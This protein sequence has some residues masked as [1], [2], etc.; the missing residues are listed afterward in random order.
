MH[1]QWLHS[2]AAPSNCHQH[3]AQWAAERDCVHHQGG[4]KVC[5]GEF[6]AIIEYECCVYTFVMFTCTSSTHY[7]TVWEPL[8][9]CSTLLFGF[10][11]SPTGTVLPT[12][13]CFF[14]RTTC[15]VRPPPG[16]GSPR[17]GTAH[18]TP[19]SCCCCI[20]CHLALHTWVTALMII[21]L[22]VCVCVS[23]HVLCMTKHTRMWFSTGRATQLKYGTNT[24]ASIVKNLTLAFTARNECMWF[25]QWSLP[26]LCV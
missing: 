24:I 16:C 8:V 1:T 23:A 9:V 17:C 14:R 12:H 15:S 5:C 10:Q 7:G 2:W 26:I 21:V 13:I 6:P 3:S 18:S 19:P 11:E 25:D 22:T 20:H 4:G